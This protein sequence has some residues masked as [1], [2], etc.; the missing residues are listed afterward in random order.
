M[1]RAQTMDFGIPH[2]QLQISQKQ[3]LWSIG[4]KSLPHNSELL[5]TRRKNLSENIVGK[6]E[7]CG[8]QHFLLFPQYFLSC[9]R[10]IV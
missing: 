9:Q 2:M 5:M 10:Q 7:N 3:S 1:K 4:D 6:G 8:N